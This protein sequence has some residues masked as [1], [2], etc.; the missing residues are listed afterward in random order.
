M[1][2]NVKKDILIMNEKN[3]KSWR[4]NINYKKGKMEMLEL[5]N[6]VSEIRN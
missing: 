4:R 5:K 2:K 1:F 3:R 6:S